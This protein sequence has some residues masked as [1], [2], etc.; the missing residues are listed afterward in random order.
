MYCHHPKNAALLI[1]IKLVDQ[2]AAV[3]PI[4]ESMNNDGVHP[5]DNG[6][7]VLANAWYATIASMI[8]SSGMGER[9]LQR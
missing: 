6:C 2:H 5:N 1:G 4:R 8:S 3:F 7:Q 9:R